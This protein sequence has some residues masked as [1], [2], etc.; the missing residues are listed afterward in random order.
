V[1]TVFY[2]LTGADRGAVL[3]VPQDAGGASLVDTQPTVAVQRG[4]G[5]LVL[6][7]SFDAPETGD[8]VDVFLALHAEGQPKTN[9]VTRVRYTLE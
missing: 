7:A 9:A 2:D 4:S 1:A 6:R 5:R 8:H 3:L